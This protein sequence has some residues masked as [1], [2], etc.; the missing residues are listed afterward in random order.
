MQTFFKDFLAMIAL[1]GFTLGA[2]TWMDF[3]TRLV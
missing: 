1:S 2:L 3:A